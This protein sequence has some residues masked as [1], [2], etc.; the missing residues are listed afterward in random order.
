M[1]INDG[2]KL[3]ITDATGRIIQESV[4]EGTSTVV[5]LSQ[6]VTGIY[7]ITLKAN[8]NEKVIRVIKN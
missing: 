5:D 3:T 7:Y 8:S 1:N 6:S 2:G 4:F